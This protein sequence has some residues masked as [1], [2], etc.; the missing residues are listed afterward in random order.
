MHI[1]RKEL[2]AVTQTSTY[3]F[4]NGNFRHLKLQHFRGF[5]VCVRQYE[6]DVV[7]EAKTVLSLPSHPVLPVLIGICC[8]KK[9]N[10]LITMFY[11]NMHRGVYMSLCGL[12]VHCQNNDIDIL[13]WVSILLAIVEGLSLMHSSGFVH[14]NLTEENIIVRKEKGRSHTF[15]PV[16]LNLEKAKALEISCHGAEYQ[17]DIEMFHSIVHKI[18]GVYN[19]K[20]ISNL[21][22]LTTLQLVKKVPANG[23][24]SEIVTYLKK[25]LSK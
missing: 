9:P 15:T 25:M 11:G 2:V 19:L 22:D 1:K 14:G 16:F 5:P 23:P 4:P 10:L 18:I 8:D 13:E 7:N 24:L 3:K 21:S 6:T 17:Q 12:I 20:G